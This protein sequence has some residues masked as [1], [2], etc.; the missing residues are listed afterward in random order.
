[1]SGGPVY[2]W[3]QRVWYGDGRF[4]WVLLPLS[5]LYWLVTSLRMERR[6][7]LVKVGDESRW[8]QFRP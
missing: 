7:P 5:G 3:L 4:G 8:L 2:D 1:M 6:S